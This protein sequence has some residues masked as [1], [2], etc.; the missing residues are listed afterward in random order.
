MH[1]H[2]A[3]ALAAILLAS[4]LAPAA[5]PAVAPPTAPV[6]APAAA[7]EEWSTIWEHWYAIE[8]AGARAGWARET[9]ARSAGRYRTEGETRLR[10][11]RGPDEVEIWSTSRF[12]ESD[13]G[14][15]QRIESQQKLAQQLVET[16]WTFTPG[17]VESVVRQGGRETSRTFPAPE[18]PWLT[19]MG[20]RRYAVAQLEAG[21]EKFSYRTISPDS[22]LEPIEV[23]NERIG[24]GDF[25]RGDRRVPVT[26]W[27]MTTSAMPGI[28]STV[29]VTADGHVV[30][31]EV[32]LPGMGKMIR[33][34][35]PRDHALAADAG[36]A[37]ELM[38]SMFV[39]VDPPIED[40]RRV[41]RATLRLAVREGEMPE[42]PSA[43][44]QRVTAEADG[45]SALMQVDVNDNVPATEE[46]IA[47]ED[48]RDASAMIDSDDALIV[49]LAQRAV[50]E[51]GDDPAA[52][53][54]ALR[55]FVHD[56]IS[57]KDL[58]TA[59]ATASETA[60]T[61][62]GDCSE[63]GVLL[64]AMMR[65]AGIPARVA[66]GLLYVDSFGGRT[67]VFGWHMWTQALLG[68]RWVDYDA[69]LPVRSDALHVLT[70]TSA[71]ADDE[72]MDDMAP[73]LLLIG[74]LEIEAVELEHGTV[75]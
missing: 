74:N 1:R 14:A 60:K 6:A 68:G 47:D 23:E 50:R 67:S 63:H 41:T 65:A 2:S 21:A 59:F 36:P 27:R 73:M 33:R 28:D 34:L 18:P 69:T 44:A 75:R 24:A 45:R 66:Y 40:A 53:A 46:E 13:D 26:R 17:G 72:G 3:P 12:V 19:P 7:A 37:P 61:R 57:A 22:G 52:R 54:E 32:A 38:V 20:V 25:D 15:P 51:A 56:H 55:R 48:Y 64:C 71:L 31:E 4:L 62:T 9:V 10:M 70:G 43:G 49:K 58:D 42:L 39:A 30:L 8:I 11:S 16:E 29:E 35:V 5:P